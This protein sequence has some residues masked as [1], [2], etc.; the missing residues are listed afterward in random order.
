MLGWLKALLGRDRPPPTGQQL[1]ELAEKERIRR[2]VE[3]ERRRAEATRA[4]QGAP[5][6][7]H[8]LRGGFG[9]W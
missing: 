6:D 8:D 9:G 5:L 3:Q 7:A 2:K 4:E 1:Q